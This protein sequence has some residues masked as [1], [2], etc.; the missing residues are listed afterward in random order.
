MKH[1]A[2][3]ASA[4]AEQE[5]LFDMLN[6]ACNGR[7]RGGALSALK[8]QKYSELSTSVAPGI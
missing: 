2:C 4:C 8:S 1:G 7:C 5:V 6:Q 3:R